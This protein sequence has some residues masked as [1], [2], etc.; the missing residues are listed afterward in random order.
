[1]PPTRSAT[2]IV[3][4]VIEKTRRHCGQNSHPKPDRRPAGTGTTESHGETSTLIA[5]ALA[6]TRESA[7]RRASKNFSR[8][9]SSAHRHAIQ[10]WTRELIAVP[11]RLGVTN[12]QVQ[13]T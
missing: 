12:T 1:L 2:P 6:C 11:S 5:R 3:G 10:P 8:V 13:Q 4:A 7:S 9:F